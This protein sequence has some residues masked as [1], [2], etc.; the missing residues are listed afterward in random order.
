MYGG[1]PPVQFADNVTVVPAVTEDE[2]VDSEEDNED[3]EAFAFTINAT[4]MIRQTRKGTAK[5]LDG[6]YT[7]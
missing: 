5:L 2:E 6:I 7:Y 3:A 4:G 1:V